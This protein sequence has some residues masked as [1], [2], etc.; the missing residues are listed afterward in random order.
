[1][2]LSFRLRPLPADRSH[3][4][5][6]C[7]LKQSDAERHKDQQASHPSW[8]CGLKHVGLATDNGQRHV[9]PFVGVWIETRI[10]SSLTTNSKS[11]P[12]WVCGLKLGCNSITQSNNRS[13]PSWV[14]GLKPLLAYHKICNDQSHPSWVCG[15][16]L[17]VR[18]NSYARQQSHPSWVCGLKLLLLCRN[19]RKFSHTLRGCVD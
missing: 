7:G 5:W 2:K 17:N 13:H 18:L 16:K 11:H 15:L 6:V 8:V 3:P 4:S 9:T 1:M 14:C 19:I 10:A 12:S